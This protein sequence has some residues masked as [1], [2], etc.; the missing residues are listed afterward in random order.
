MMIMKRA[1]VGITAAVA[2]AGFSVAN[3]IAASAAPLQQG[4]PQCGTHRT[5][6]VAYGSR[7]TAVKFLQCELNGIG[8]GFH[9]AEDGDFGGLTY[10]AVITFQRRAMGAGAVDGIVG[11]KTWNRLLCQCGEG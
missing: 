1:I 2:V 3:P 11:P 10:N 4:Y 8:W 6:T 9:L 7:G 5:E